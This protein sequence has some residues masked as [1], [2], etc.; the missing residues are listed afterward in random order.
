MND[1]E[2][3]NRLYNLRVKCKLSQSELGKLVGVTNKAVSKW[4]MGKAKP[5]IKIINKLSL[6]FNVKLEELMNGEN[7]EPVITKIVITGGP[8][9]GKSTALS[10]IQNEFVQKGYHVIFINEAATELISNGISNVTCES[11][12]L[13]QEALMKLQIEREKIYYEAARKMNKDKIL[14]VCDRGALD[15]KAFL[16]DLDFQYVLKSLSASA[17]P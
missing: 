5:G 3:G 7:K 6:I 14:I 8:C 15:S 1:Y 17:K 10:W 9:A 11:S 12:I 16:S 2:F 4:E 13:F